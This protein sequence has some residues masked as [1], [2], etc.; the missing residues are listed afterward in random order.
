M[1]AAQG[2]VK[3]MKKMEKGWIKQSEL[4]LAPDGGVSQLTAVVGVVVSLGFLGDTAASV[5]KRRLGVKDFGWV[6]GRQGGWMDRLDSSLFLGLVP[7]S[8]AAGYL[9][10]FRC[11]FA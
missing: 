1:M 4:K 6:L 2:T 10:A 3:G 7:L 8:I 5:L 11:A 9:P